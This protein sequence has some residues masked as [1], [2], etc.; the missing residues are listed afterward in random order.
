MFKLTQNWS[1]IFCNSL[2]H[3]KVSPNNR[4]C[5]FTFN[6]TNFFNL[7]LKFINHSITLPAKDLFENIIQIIYLTDFLLSGCQT[8]IVVSQCS[9]FINSCLHLDYLRDIFSFFGVFFTFGICRRTW[10]RAVLD[11]V[12]EFQYC[13]AFK[14]SIS[15]NGSLWIPNILSKRTH[16]PALLQTECNFLQVSLARN[17]TSHLY[18]SFKACQ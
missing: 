8:N 9:Q 13:I 2:S 1:S 16:T 12:P 15:L 18:N 6:I 10:V 3:Q 11:Q 5:I 14:Y 7:L 4:E 17:A